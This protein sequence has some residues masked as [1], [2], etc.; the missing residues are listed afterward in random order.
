MSIKKVG[1]V[2]CGQM[3]SSIALL[4]AQAGLPT[5]V[6]ELNED[7][8]NEGLRNVQNL[9]NRYITKGKLLKRDKDT[10]D[11]NLIG[12]TTIE[13]FADCDLVIEAILEDAGE[14]KKLFA[15]LDSVCSPETILASNTF[16]LP[17]TDMASVTQ[18]PDK[19]IGMRFFYPVVVMTLL[20]IVTT[21]LTSEETVKTAKAFGESLGKSII[22]SK[23]EPGFVVNRLVAPFLLDAIRLLESGVAS[24]EDIDASMV[25]GLNHPMGPLRL[26]DLI[27]LDNVLYVT[28]S[29][30]E[31]LQEEKF[32]PPQILVNMVKAGHLGRKASKGFYEYK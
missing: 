23:D 26:S 27:G 7:L 10:V 25:L 8:L 9:V 18:R 4:T 2:G 17:I 22:I 3:G 14:K 1:V 30:Y 21:I 13:D 5:V 31:Q 24:R 11:A 6:S 19:V 16:S 12:T 29:L 32:A 15:E 20:E 28:Q